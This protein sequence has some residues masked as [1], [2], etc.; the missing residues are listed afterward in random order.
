MR[1]IRRTAIILTLLLSGAI[2]AGVEQEIIIFFRGDVD[3]SGSV[4]LSDA[5][6]LADY[7]FAGGTEPESCEAVWDVDDSGSANITDV[8]FLFNHLFAGG[9]APPSDPVVCY[10]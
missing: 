9:P 7:L 6:Q 4:N 1:R 8:N 3:G 2:D 5:V 10:Y